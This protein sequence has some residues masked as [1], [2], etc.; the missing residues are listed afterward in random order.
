MCAC[1]VCLERTLKGP[2][3]TS[4]A[5]AERVWPKLGTPLPPIA[6]WRV[7]SVLAVNSLWLSTQTSRWPLHPAHLIIISGTVET[8]VQRLFRVL[9]SSVMGIQEMCIFGCTLGP[10][11]LVTTLNRWSKDILRVVPLKVKGI[12]VICIFGYNIG[13]VLSTTTLQRLF[14]CVPSV[15]LE[16]NGYTRH[17]CI[18]GCNLRPVISVTMTKRLSK[19]IVRV[20]L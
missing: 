7:E 20:V 19:G 13:P 18:F 2:R 1:G 9:S 10:V 5:R 6:N 12:Q 16:G 11:L 14:K 17:C 8:V 15:M 4:L 3:L